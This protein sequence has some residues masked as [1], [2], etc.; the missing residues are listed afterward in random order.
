MSKTTPTKSNPDALVPAYVIRQRSGKVIFTEGHTRAS[1]A[2]VLGYTPHGDGGPDR[3]LNSKARKTLKLWV[4]G[5]QPARGAM[6]T[7]GGD[8]TSVKCVHCPTI[9]TFATVQLDRKDAFGPYNR[10][11]TQPACGPCNRKRGCAGQTDPR[12]YGQSKTN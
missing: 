4:L 11:N 1:L 10:D 12:D 3:R 8:G 5:N 6:A 2:A 9:L 7:F